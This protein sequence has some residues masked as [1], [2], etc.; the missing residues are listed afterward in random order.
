MQHSDPSLSKYFDIVGVP[1]KTIKSTKN[2]SKSLF[3]LRICGRVRIF[4]CNEKE[5]VEI[6]VPKELR[7]K[8]LTLAHD[9]TFSARL[10]T[11]M[12][13]YRLTLPFY[14]PGVSCDVTKYCKSCVICLKTKPKGETPKALLQIS[15]VFDRPFYKCAIDLIGHLP[16]SASKSKMTLID[17]TTRWVDNVALKKHHSNYL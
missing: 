14:W 9:K 1:P 4:S 11:R 7:A 16:I 15:P 13:L 8:I 17:Y 10:G 3:E 12:I 6:M 5:T 2:I